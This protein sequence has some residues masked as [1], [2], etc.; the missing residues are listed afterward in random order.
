MGWWRWARAIGES[1]SMVGFMQ[2]SGFRLP[3]CHTF[4]TVWSKKLT[5]TLTSSTPSPS[6]SAQVS[7]LTDMSIAGRTTGCGERPEADTEVVVSAL[8]PIGTGDT[9]G[10]ARAQ[11]QMPAARSIVVHEHFL[12]RRPKLSKISSLT[13]YMVMT[14][15]ESE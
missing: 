10:A 11:V 7:T 5:S 15:A 3:Q 9:T 6:T 8:I 14:G 4:C 2:E 13:G 1:G 12:S